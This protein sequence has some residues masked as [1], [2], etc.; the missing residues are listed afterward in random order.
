MVTAW[1][2]QSMIRPV[3]IRRDLFMPDHIVRNYGVVQE[4]RQF[5]VHTRILVCAQRT[6]LL[7][8]FALDKRRQ[9]VL[10]CFYQ[11]PDHFSGEL[12]VTLKS[13]HQIGVLNNLAG[14]ALAETLEAMILASVVIPG[15]SL[16]Q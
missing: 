7:N 3:V 1:L 6:R 14:T 12:H 8:I 15:I 10:A 4:D 2:T 9:L 16:C 11:A 13:I 5:L